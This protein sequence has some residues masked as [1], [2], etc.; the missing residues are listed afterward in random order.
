[1]CAVTKNNTHALPPQSRQGNNAFESFGLIRFP[2][3]ASFI[4]I[5]VNFFLCCLWP[6]RGAALL[7]FLGPLV[8]YRIGLV[9]AINAI[10]YLVAGAYYKAPPPPNTTPSITHP[11]V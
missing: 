8:S 2:I 5:I 1:M 7:W 9:I 3:A 4:Q 6:E 11:C 10:A